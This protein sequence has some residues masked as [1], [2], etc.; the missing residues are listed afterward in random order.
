MEHTRCKE[1]S[2]QRHKYVASGE[3]GHVKRWWNVLSQVE[4]RMDSDRDNSC[5]EILDSDWVEG[6]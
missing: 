6:L 1:R 3:T 5:Y 4:S 2:V